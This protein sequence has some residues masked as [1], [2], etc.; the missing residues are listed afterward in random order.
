[1][2]QI[3]CSE[4]V[5]SKPEDQYYTNG[6]QGRHSKCIDCWSKTGINGYQGELKRRF[7]IYQDDNV[8][9]CLC[10]RFY[11]YYKFNKSRRIDNRRTCCTKCVT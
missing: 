10:G 5:D 11:T 4:C 9:I 7:F 6:K 1:M 3:V 2:K 8:G